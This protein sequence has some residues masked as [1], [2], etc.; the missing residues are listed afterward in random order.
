MPRTMTHIPGG[1]PPVGDGDGAGDGPGAGWAGVGDGPGAGWV[2]A[3]DG[4]GAG[5]AGDGLG[6]GAGVVGDGP[7]GDVGAGLGCPAAAG[8]PGPGERLAMAT[9]WAWRR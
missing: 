5:W 3:G 8:C 7:L 2:G 1:G 9:G 6:P 4:P